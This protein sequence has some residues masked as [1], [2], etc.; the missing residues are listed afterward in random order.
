MLAVLRQPKFALFWSGSLVSLIGDWML[1]IAL[2]IYVFNLTGSTLATGITFMIEALPRILLGSVAGVFVDRWDRKRVLVV[3]DVLRAI[4]ILLLLTVQSSQDVW[5]VY[6]AAALMTIIGQFAGPAIGALIPELVDDSDLMAANSLNSLSSNLTRLVGP[7]LGGALMALVGFGSVVLIDSASFAIS[8]ILIAMM[9]MRTPKASAPDEATPPPSI[10]WT[11]VWREWWAGLQVVSRDRTLASIFLIIA[12]V[13]PAEGILQVLFVV[14][15]KRLLC[16]DA[17][18]FGLIIGAQAV[19]G[20]AASLAIARVS[21][22]MPASRL[23]GLSGVCNGLLL[24]VIFN[25]PSLPLAMFLFFLAGF[26][27]V[28]FFVS[29]TTLLQANAP[30]Q[31]LGR[32]FGAFGTTVSLATLLGMGIATVLGDIL[33]ASILLNL[34]AILNISAGL[35]A[36]ILLRA[37]A[38]EPAVSP[39]AGQV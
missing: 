33:G 24:L 6:L 21:Q 3:T 9:I 31:Y 17:Q 32:V 10:T 7:P 27:V 11:Q 29:L 1:F 19:G 5:I 25:F 4:V 37:P 14:F 36:S 18:E 15:V 16:G 22:A 12:A 28:G 20:I 23:V 26:P 8:A 30:D 35:L 39:E 38:T 2:P 34:V 13:M